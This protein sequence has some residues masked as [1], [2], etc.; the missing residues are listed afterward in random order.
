MFSQTLKHITFE[1]ARKVQQ[2]NRYRQ[3]VRELHALT[4]R[5]LA[6]LGIS[7]GE[8]ERIAHEHSSKSTANA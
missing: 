4:D 7:R 5:D 3:T 6:D 8:I 1:I 2:N